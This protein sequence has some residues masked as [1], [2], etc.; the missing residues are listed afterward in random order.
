MI[1]DFIRYISENRLFEDG[2]RILLAVSGGID[3]MVMW[4]LFEMAGYNYAVAHCNFCLRGVDSDADESLVRNTA[5]A[6]GV[7]LFVRRFETT[8]YASAAG[9]SIE[10]AARELR[11]N[12]FSEL[13]RQEQFGFVATAHHQDD[14][15]E[16]FFINL[17]RK[18]G[19]KGLTGFRPKSGNLIRPML[20]SNRQEIEQWSVEHKVEYRTDHTN[21]ELV[22]KRNFIRHRIIPA[23]EE[24]NPA[25]RKNLADTMKNLRSAEMFYDTEINRQI[26]RITNQEA[27]NPEILIS[28]LLKLPHPQQVLYEWMSRFGF[29][30]ATSEQVYRNLEGVSGRQFF[31]PTH[32]L[33]TGRN[34][35]IMTPI[36]EKPEEIFYIEQED[37]E[38][39]EPIHLTFTRQDAGLKEI[40]PDPRVAFLDA[41]K[42]RFPLMVRHWNAGEYFQPFGMTG[43]KKVSDFFIDQKFS[44]PEKEQTWILYSG[45]K[46]VWIIGHRMDNRFRISNET[47]KVL[48]VRLHM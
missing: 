42:L 29:N 46:V 4:Q 30:P 26:K 18:T 48:V 12:W 15:L 7:R 19:I 23:L 41:E 22:Y 20:Y 5:E 47:K 6:R 33:V 14:L 31:S 16:T 32:R 3:S 13:I 1:H 21:N 38:V 28:G 24:L 17:L 45:D 39:F 40:D 8:E 25:F 27:N 2:D 10:M 34:R 37:L 44:I 36:Q 35:L 43:F 9:V 11:Y